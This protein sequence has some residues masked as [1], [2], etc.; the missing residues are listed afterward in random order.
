MTAQRRSVF[1][2]RR[3]ELD[4]LTT[5][6][7]VGDDASNDDKNEHKGEEPW[8]PPVSC[9]E[10]VDLRCWVRSR[11]EAALVLE[12]LPK[13]GKREALSIHLRRPRVCRCLGN[14]MILQL[15]GVWITRRPQQEPRV[16]WC[17]G[18]TPEQSRVAMSAKERQASWDGQSTSIRSRVLV[19]G[20]RV[21]AE[22]GEKVFSFFCGL[23]ASCAYRERTLCAVAT[24]GLE[25]EDSL[26]PEWAASGPSRLGC[27]RRHVDV[28]RR[29]GDC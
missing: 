1:L 26:P 8:P 28:A 21:S 19:N 27:R 15:P 20:R 12:Y 9:E 5:L 17:S 29:F 4:R 10:Q 16:G 14:K 24:K 3:A 22:G 18:M 13:G 7:E 6:G 23:F 11:Q 2:E 25:D